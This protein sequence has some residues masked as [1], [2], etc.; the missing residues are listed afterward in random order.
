[1]GKSKHAKSKTAL[2]LMKTH[3]AIHKGID[4]PGRSERGRGPDSSSVWKKVNPYPQKAGR[5]RK[6]LKVICTVPPNADLNMRTRGCFS[7]LIYFMKA[8]GHGHILNTEV[9]FC[10]VAAQ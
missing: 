8:A 6:Q 3:H 1:M 7:C 4:D 10:T 2:W 9:I 5:D